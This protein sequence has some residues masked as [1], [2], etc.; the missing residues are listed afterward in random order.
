MMPRARLGDR[1]VVCK[2]I[3]ISF[4]FTDNREDRYVRRTVHRPG[5]ACRNV[6]CTQNVTPPWKG[7]QVYV[8]VCGLFFQNISCPAVFA[9]IPVGFMCVGDS[10]PHTYDN[11]GEGSG[12]LQLFPRL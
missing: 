10:L 9:L 2:C 8:Y 4:S 3:L 1:D 5:R 6:Y 11:C 7:S 12:G